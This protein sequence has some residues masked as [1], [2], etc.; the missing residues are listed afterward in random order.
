MRFSSVILFKFGYR[1]T[2]ISGR[3]LWINLRYI[4]M[5]EWLIGFYI[6]AAVIFTLAET[7]PLVNRLLGGLF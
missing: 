5:A 7:M 6:M 1:D 4:V 2:T 3:F